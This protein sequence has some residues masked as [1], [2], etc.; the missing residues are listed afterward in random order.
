M[1]RV[2]MVVISVM[3]GLAATAQA[4]ISL[5]VGARGGLGG[6]AF[7][8]DD[9]DS[10][11]L[12]LGLGGGLTMALHL[13]DIVA[14]RPE[15]AFALRGARYESRYAFTVLG[16]T[17]TAEIR[18][19]Y[20]LT[21]LEIPVLI[22]LRPR[23]SGNLRPLAYIGV[24]PAFNI[25]AKSHVESDVSN[26]LTGGIEHHEDEQDIEGDVTDVDF[27]LVGGAG[28]ELLVGPGSLLIEVRG[29]I[30]VAPV[31]EKNGGDEPEIHNSSFSLE[32]GYRW[33]LGG[34]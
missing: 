19:D 21:Y 31:F 8:G 27:A 28:I 29:T 24:Q 32:L 13:G 25:A 20:L 4:G 5:S 17:Y 22:E 26:P 9:A 16:A 33:P 6:A 2:M 7:I 23:L 3:C 18:A 10:L 14:V 30:G 12:R 15:F 34:K 11:D 1:R